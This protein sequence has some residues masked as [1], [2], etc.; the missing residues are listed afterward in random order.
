M[1]SLFLQLDHHSGK[2]FKRH[3]VFLFDFPV[4]TDQMIL[5]VDTTEIAIAEED[6]PDS[7]RSH[8][9][10]LFSEVRCVGRNDREISGIAAGDFVPNAVVPTVVRTDI[11]G[12]K[13]GL[14]PF[15]TVPKLTGLVEVD[16]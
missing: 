3:L 7:M 10:R 2:A 13:H 15:H 16:V 5:T 12:R 4:L 14:K 9:E 1:A 6:V 11:A 8:E